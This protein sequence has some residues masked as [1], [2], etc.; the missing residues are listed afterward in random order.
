[1]MRNEL[2]FSNMQAIIEAIP[3]PVFVRDRNHRIVLLNESTCIF[4]GRSREALLIEGDTSL[5]PREEVAAFRA[6]DALV[7]DGGDDHESENQI[8]GAEGRIRDVI[9]SRRLAYLSGQPH[10]VTVLTDVTTYRA[11]AD[12][13]RYL[14]LHDTLT[15]LPNRALLKDRI[16]QCLGQSAQCAL[17]YIDLDQ[18]KAVND[19]HGHPIGDELIQEFG[20]RLSAIARASDTVARLSGDE[21]AV[22]I[23]DTAEDP[24]AED[25]CKRALIAASRAF[26]LTGCQVFVGASV[27]VVLSEYADVDCAE[28]QRRADVALYQAKSE[29]RGCYRMFTRGL[30]D[31]V[32]KREQLQI[33]LRRALATQS[34]LELHYQPLLN[35]ASGEVEGFEALARWRHPTLGNISPVEFIPLAETGGMIVELGEWVLA[36]ACDDAMKWDRRS[37]CR[38]TFRRS[39][40]HMAIWPRRWTG[41]CWRAGSIRRGW[42]SRSPR[43]C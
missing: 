25:V 10:V 3:N 2:A 26:E 22:L 33:D 6:A 9:A 12:R 18:F 14:A 42:I 38:S 37:A 40:S 8:I 1:M 41:C 30:D 17:L 19:T 36:K 11:T 23:S 35:I 39:S 31:S 15:G 13:H 28:L 4:L 24:R 16:N 43:G 5:F 20:R 27:G 34:G 29:G 32:R 7:F 21:F